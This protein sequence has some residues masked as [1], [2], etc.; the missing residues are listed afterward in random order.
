MDHLP[1]DPR[2]RRR[3]AGRRPLRAVET[4]IFGAERP[5]ARCFGCCGGSVA[6]PA[7][8]TRR[9]ADDAGGRRGRA[10]ADRGTGGMAAGG[11]LDLLAEHVCGPGAA[12]GPG[13]VTSRTTSRP[14]MLR[15]LASRQDVRP[16][17]NVRAPRP[18]LVPGIHWACYPGSLNAFSDQV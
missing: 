12:V 13:A 11:R 10:G 8:M 7:C 6:R 5:A 2:R 3:L 14:A 9:G 1:G 4:W 18:E 16:W 17:E 15:I